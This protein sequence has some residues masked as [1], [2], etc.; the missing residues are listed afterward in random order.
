MQIPGA[1]LEVQWLNSHALLWWPRVC[2]FRSRTQTSTQLIKLCCGSVSHIKWRKIG[3]DVSSGPI[4][5]TH[6]HTK[7]DSWAPALDILCILTSP[8]LKH[9]AITTFKKWQHDPKKEA[10]LSGQAVGKL[11][12][13]KPFFFLAMGQGTDKQSLSMSDPCRLQYKF[14]F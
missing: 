3:T 9:C 13:F 10:F 2:R 5:L 6:T 4:F 1:R 8:L 12:L 7:S 11:E 14:L